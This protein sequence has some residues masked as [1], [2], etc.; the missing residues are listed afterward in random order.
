[1]MKKPLLSIIVPTLNEEERIGRLLQS[2]EEQSFKDF[3][4]VVVDGGSSDNTVKVAGE[5]SAK[6]IVKN[7]CKEF[8]S[9]NIG[10]KLS[11]GNIL[12]FLS[13]DVVLSR[14]ALKHLAEAFL[15]DQD[16]SGVCSLGIPFDAPLWMKIEY[17]FHWRLLR[18]W[19]GLTKDYHASTNFMAV[20]KVDFHKVGGFTDEIFADT[21]FFNKL[22]KKYKVKVLPKPLVFVSGRRAKKMGFTK[23]TTHFL[24]VF[25]FDYFPFLR[26]SSIAKFLQSYSSDYRARHQ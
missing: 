6:V 2:L 23:F 8:P 22:G 25:L 19:M 21:I 24:W 14:D 7:G 12:L 3:E 10:A 20:R 11:N 18:I 1:M 9:R 4:I 5:F 13:A 15:E 17:L 16:V 26:K